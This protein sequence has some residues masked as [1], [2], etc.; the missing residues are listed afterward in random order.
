MTIQVLVKLAAIDPWSFTVLD[1]LRR[2]FGCEE[3][4]HVERITCWELEFRP[5]ATPNFALNPPA[6]QKDVHRGYEP[7]LSASSIRLAQPVISW[8]SS[9][10]T[11]L[12]E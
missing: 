10:N 9:W 7:P 12:F 3:V 11:G 6:A 8:Y 2:K 1:T 5:E 4:T